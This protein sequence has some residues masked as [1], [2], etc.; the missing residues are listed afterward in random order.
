M[1]RTRS[2]QAAAATDPGRERSNNED[3]VL[4]EPDLGIFAVID[5]VGGESAGEVAAETALE[6]LRA[7]LSRRTTDS[8]R[9]VREA[10]ALANRQI[11]ERARADA[12][13][14]GMSCVLTVAVLDGAKVT[15]GQVGDSRLYALAPG[16]I[17]KVT[18]DHSPVG[19]REDAGDIS[20][21]EA[22]RHPRRNE[23]FRDV[24]SG[25]HEPDDARWIDVLEVPFDAGGALLLCSDGLSDMLP[26]QEILETVERNAASPRAAVRALIERANAA[27]GKDNV[28]AVLV[29]G[30][31]FAE[32]VRRRRDGT[33]RDGRGRAGRGGG[34]DRGA[35]SGGGG[36]GTG[37]GLREPGG[38]LRESGGGIREPGGTGAGRPPGDASRKA[39]ASAGRGAAAAG[40]R[41]GAA[42]ARSSA[43]GRLPGSLPAQLGKSLLIVALLLLAAFAAYRYREP[44]M[45]W[46]HGLGGHLP[47]SG[48]AGTPGGVLVVGTG[49][50]GLATIGEALA[51]ARPG[52]TIEV[53]PGQYRERI[54][55]R[56][57]VSV[58]SRVPRGATL[59][60]PPGAGAPAVTAAAVRG[61]RLAGFRIAGAPREAL[62]GGVLLDGSEVVVE[63]VEVTGA[64]GP[65]IESRGADRS[66]VRYC[67]VHHNAG[68]GIVVDGD[69]AP[70]LL[71]NLVA[72][73]GTR[74]GAPAAGIEVRSAAAPLLAG[75]RIEG[76]GGAGVVLPGP[77]RIEEV[78]RWNSFGAATRE[79]AVRVAG[80]ASPAPAPAGAAPPSGTAAAAASRARRRP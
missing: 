52:E 63:E 59:L 71:S 30:E 46:L 26:S 47:G 38:G 3:R 62:A 39:P 2:P 31:R 10:I 25:P 65:G 28:S 20:E 73:N 6:V 41:G 17:R 51:R 72:G 33:G 61:A 79:Q 75:N 70:R 42:W 18:P 23:I 29:E 11:F 48:G 44:L 21:L 8:A 56:S 12:R 24:G 68:P 13:L 74:P 27:G 1:S 53:A 67:Y 7:R 55:L 57:G 36:A 76:N 14:A 45:S 16:E 78:F 37:G 34:G 15:V 49:D 40:G 80:G 43:G 22:M 4:C 5:G 60:P 32:A 66:T 77:E 19:A 9:L 54:A 64:A 69:A 50:G 35:G 58:V